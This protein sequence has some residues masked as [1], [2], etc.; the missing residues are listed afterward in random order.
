M[1]LQDVAKRQ[2]L[3]MVPVEF[4]DIDPAFNP[5][6]MTSADTIS[7]VDELAGF[8]EAQGFD[9]DQPL[10]GRLEGEKFIVT[11]GHCRTTAVRKLIAAGADIKAIPCRLEIRGT[12]AFDRLALSLTEPGKRLNAMETSGAIKRMLGFG[13]DEND[14]AKRL[15]RTRQWVMSALDLAGAPEPIKAAVNGGR[16]SATEAVRSVRHDPD[17]VATLEAATVIAADRGSLKVRPKDIRATRAPATPSIPAAPKS[18]TVR[19]LTGL[20]AVAA[21]DGFEGLSAETQ[22]VVLGLIEQMEG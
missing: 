6:D 14:I 3:F 11:R 10:L 8:I 13:H 16:M 2:D 17:P 7:W 9:P 1:R 12:S 20:Q 5:R 22:G 15:G 18:F 19:A 4:I 21:D